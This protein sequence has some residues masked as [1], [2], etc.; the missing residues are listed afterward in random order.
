LGD[1]WSI[2]NGR[3]S[4]SAS[5]PGSSLSQTVTFEQGKKYTIKYYVYAEAEAEGYFHIQG[6]FGNQDIA[7]TEGEHTYTFTCQNTSNS[8]SF[9]P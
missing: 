7:S 3:A 2:S 8:L 9:F 5:A 6:S 4:R 1:N